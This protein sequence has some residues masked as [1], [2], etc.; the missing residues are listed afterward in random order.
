MS[1]L[2]VSAEM[3]ASLRYGILIAVG[4]AFLALLG[5]ISSVRSQAIKLVSYVVPFG[6]AA[7]LLSTWVS[8]EINNEPHL[9]LPHLA[10]VVIILFL[11]FFSDALE[12]AYTS[13]RYKLGDQFSA[14]EQRILSEM[15]QGDE[16]LIYEAR[17]WL[18]TFLIVILTLMGDFRTVYFFRW[19]IEDLHV[20][21][22]FSISAGTLFSL[23]FTTFPVLWLAQGLSKRVAKDCPQKMLATGGLVWMLIK[24]IG[25]ITGFLGLDRP[26]EII[27]H[28]LKRSRTFSPELNLRA[29]DYTYYVASLLRYGY[30][31]HDLDVSI[32]IGANGACFVRQRVLYYVVSLSSDVFVRKLETDSEPDSEPEI[33]TLAAFVG[34]LVR[35]SD[36]RGSSSV[37]ESDPRGSSSELF[38]ELDQLA[39]EGDG[40]DTTKKGLFS[41][42]PANL[43]LHAIHEN[44]DDRRRVHYRIDTHGSVDTSEAAFAQLVDFKT[45]W[46][47]GAFRSSPNDQDTYYMMFECPCYRYR[48]SID[49]DPL[50]KLRISDIK[51][52]ALCGRDNHWG[53]QDRLRRS[54]VYNDNSP[55]ALSCELFYPFPGIQYKFS[56]TVCEVKPTSETK[57]LPA[58]TTTTMNS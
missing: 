2:K 19:K 40:L 10:I 17:E 11:I 36:S 22:F 23:F 56:W 12:V 7:V 45:L 8:T 14:V 54:L 26:T 48:L 16:I 1:N 9:L 51:A 5:L 3:V 32:V 4:I 25:K 29:S 27:A 42:I 20:W 58:T 53:E 30:A 18:V 6:L 33:N 44:P 13:L 21:D 52:Q 15:H 37:S 39:R 24:T 28:G 55:K 50:C 43:S 49:F 41:R 34:T 46:K 47:P 38:E 57:L 35:E 31:L